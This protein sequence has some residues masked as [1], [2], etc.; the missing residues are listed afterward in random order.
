[1]PTRTQKVLGRL[2]F[3]YKTY[4][5]A[6][7]PRITDYLWRRWGLKVLCRRLGLKEYRFLIHRGHRDWFCWLSFTP[8]HLGTSRYV[9]LIL[10]WFEW[11]L[12]HVP[13]KHSR[14]HR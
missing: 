7:Q 4:H 14:W 12:E 9:H 2:G 3:K 8:P 5:R 6:G 11:Y 1:M 10:P 13:G